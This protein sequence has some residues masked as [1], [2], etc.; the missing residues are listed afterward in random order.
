MLAGVALLLTVS[1]QD[2]ATAAAVTGRT[3]TVV[4]RDPPPGAQPLV[5]TASRVPSGDS[6]KPR[7]PDVLICCSLTWFPP[8]SGAYMALGRNPTCRSGIFFIVT[9]L[10]AGL[11]RRMKNVIGCRLLL[12]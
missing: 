4:T 3:L 11:N 5:M 9:C 7:T 1:F 12:V 10:V 6:A 8:G 2:R